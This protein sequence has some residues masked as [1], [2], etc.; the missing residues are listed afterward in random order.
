MIEPNP[1]FNNDPHHSGDH[2]KTHMME[3]V[4]CGGQGEEGGG[5]ALD[6]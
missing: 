5:V 6:N 3:A 2:D 4:L 1:V